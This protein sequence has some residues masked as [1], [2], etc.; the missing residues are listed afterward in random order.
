MKKTDPTNGEEFYCAGQEGHCWC[1]ELPNTLPVI[2]GAE[3]IG[4]TRLKE[5]TSAEPNDRASD[6]QD[7]VGREIPTQAP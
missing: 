4:P 6:H 5:L 1:F 2:P 3:C 7:R